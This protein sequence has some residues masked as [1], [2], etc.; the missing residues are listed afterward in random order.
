MCDVALRYTKAAEAGH[1]EAQYNL[2][3]CYDDGEG[4]AQDKRKAVEWRV[5]D[6][7]HTRTPHSHTHTSHAS[8]P[9]L[10]SLSRAAGADLCVCVVLCDVALRFTKAAEPGFAAAQW[11]LGSC[12]AGGLG[13]S[14]D[15]AEG[16][17]WM[18]LAA[19]QGFE[20]ANEWLRDN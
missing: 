12:Y 10:A 17:R 11:A 20:D 5:V 18:Q 13:V 19:D 4:V 15:M 9:S 6:G 16:R 14:L 1:A 8:S 2:G 7:T 3:V